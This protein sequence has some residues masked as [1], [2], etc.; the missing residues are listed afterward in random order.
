M[1]YHI[2]TTVKFANECIENGIYGATN[3]NW[4]A[5]IEFGDFVFISQF[6]YKSQN[7]YGPFKVAETLFYDKNIIYPNQKYYYRIKL[8]PSKVKVIDET[9]LYLNGIKNEN[10]DLAYYII[11]LIQQNKH[12]H[13][14]SLV[15]QEGKFILETIEKLGN[16][17]K[18]ESVNNHSLDFETH[19]VDTNFLIAKNKLFKKL[20]FSSESDLEAFILLNLK[21]ENSILY[22]QIDKILNEFQKNYLGNSITYN[23]FIF[24]NAYPA[25]IVIINKE[26]INIFELKKDI[27]DQNPLSILRKEMKK[28]CYYSLFSRRIQNK[29]IKRMNFFLL[30]L[31]DANNKTKKDLY[32]EFSNINNFVSNLRENNFIILEYYIDNGR[33]FIKKV[34]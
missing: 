7:I 6:N 25:D 32:R 19:K 10:I 22:K 23:Q 31:K 30:T 17:T 1:R 27:L 14:I 9:D 8:D 15:E 2:L 16:K 20:S 4:L 3:S 5:N 13:S 24:G 33:L 28:Y 12:L 29:D 21:N 11:N 34:N 18:I 26:N